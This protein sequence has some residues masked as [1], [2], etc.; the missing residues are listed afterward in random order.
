M[1]GNDFNQIIGQLE[2]S[3]KVKE[4]LKSQSNLI[5]SIAD[6]VVA[7]FQRGN[8]VLFCGN[9]GSAAD[10]QHLAAEFAGRFY[11]DREPLPALALHTNSSIVT[12]I[13]NDYHFDEVYQRQ[14][15]ALAVQ[16]D[17]VIGI[18]TSG[19]SRN[20]ILAVEE[21][22]RKGAITIAFTGSGGNLKEI[23]DICLDVVSRDTPRIQE[24]HITAGHI[25]CY[26]VENVLF[27]G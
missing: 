24:A 7:A 16:G 15:R 13:S 11:L 2:E 18:S 3:I 10:A 4:A 22:K 23:A 21:A 5:K 14:V 8:K 6:E 17:V 20:I 26:L 9:G 12:A 1:M 25:I 27:G 19:N